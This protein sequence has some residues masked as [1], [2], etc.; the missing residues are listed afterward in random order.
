MNSGLLKVNINDLVHAATSAVAAAV[1]I[2][3]GSIVSQPNFD[4]FALDWG[5]VLHSCVNWGVAA[6]VGSIVKSLGTTTEGNF[7]GAIKL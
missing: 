2:G 5:T 7:L 6:F 1:V 3:L 4:V